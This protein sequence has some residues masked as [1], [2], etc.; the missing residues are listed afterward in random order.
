MV[1]IQDM[2]KIGFLCFISLFGNVEAESLKKKSA[3]TL[4]TQLETLKQRDILHKVKPSRHTS[5]S[6]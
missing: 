1:K 6:H 3:N 5:L 4:E 2:V